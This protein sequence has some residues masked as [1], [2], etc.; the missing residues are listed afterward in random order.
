MATQPVVAEQTTPV[1]APDG[2]IR[3]IPDVKLRDAFASGGK[4]A[5][6]VKTP[7]G[8]VRYI[9]HDQV[10]P[11]LAAGGQINTEQGTKTEPHQA[12]GFWHSLGSVFGLTKEQIQASAEARAKDIL[13]RGGGKATVGGVLGNAIDTAQQGDPAHVVAGIVRNTAEAAPGLAKKAYGEAAASNE[14]AGRGDI[15]QFLAHQ[16]GGMGYT[17][18]TAASPLLGDAPAK[19]GEQFGEGNIKGGMGT[20]AGVV[21]PFALPEVPG[22]MR[23]AGTGLEKAAPYVGKGAKEAA[24]FGGVGEFIHTG[25][26]IALAGP[27]VAPLVE[28]GA[29]AATAGI[30]RLIRRTGEGFKAEPKSAVAEATAA[31]P[32]PTA[33]APA[34]T[35]APE[36]PAAQSA[37]AAKSGNAELPRVNSGEGVLTQALTALDNKTLLKVA[38][39]RGIDVAKEA[40]LKAGAANSGIIR[41]I[42]DDFSVDELDEVRNKGIEIGLHKPVPAEGVTPEAGAEAWH[43]KVLNTFFPDVAVPKAMAAR[44]EATIAARPSGAAVEAKARFEAARA[45]AEGAANAVPNDT[46]QFAYRVRDAGET[47]INPKG[48]AQ[49]TLDLPQAQSYVEGR[50]NLQGAPQELVKVDL[51]KINPKDY[52]LMTGPG[53]KTWVKFK[54]SVPESVIEKVDGEKPQLAT[55]SNTMELLKKS[56]ERAR[57]AKAS[58]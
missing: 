32:V 21:A 28:K 9:P 27:A 43:Y 4:L 25:N 44:A 3:Q 23:A 56:F 53:G 42:L 46:P 50:G 34:V 2:S 38:K 26:P 20:T 1:F 5:V 57:A 31:G 33:E 30:G 19:A 29:T 10:G 55:E 6:Q 49:A 54:S 35:P 45:K 14:A 40:Q 24:R 11:A 13:A 37:E 41:K 52:Q 51:S 7:T 22:A 39:S 16:I 8:D 47:G 48:H 18:A 58:K 15:V 12:E 36:T 17:A